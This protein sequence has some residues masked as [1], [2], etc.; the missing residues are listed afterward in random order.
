[1]NQD[2]GT[3]A[4]E[5]IGNSGNGDIAKQQLSEWLDVIHNSLARPTVRSQSWSEELEA[6]IPRT[7]QEIN[8]NEAPQVPVTTSTVPLPSIW[9]NFDVSKLR[10]AGFK[11]DLF[12]HQIVKERK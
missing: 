5:P 9:D 7:S 8:L 10:N 3:I 6:Q 2:Q 4:P 12:R 1:M 11:L